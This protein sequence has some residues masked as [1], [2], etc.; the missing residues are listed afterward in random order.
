ME[1]DPDFLFLFDDDCHPIAHN[2]HLP[3]L[4]A[5]HSQL[6][7]PH[8][9]YEPTPLSP[10]L[11]SYEKCMGAMLCF[12]REAIEIL[13][14]YDS[15]PA[16]Y[17]FEHAQISQRAYK[18][19]LIPA[20]YISPVNAHNLLYALDVSPRY[21]WHNIPHPANPSSC[22]LAEINRHGENLSRLIDPPI[23][24]ERPPLC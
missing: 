11:S 12:S 6:I 21:T 1:S 20:P 17:G 13:G 14:G 19:G 16:P 8:P 3:F 9:G 15:F 24:I 23:Y 10:N 22:T 7:V 4:T 2:W 18:A 5:H